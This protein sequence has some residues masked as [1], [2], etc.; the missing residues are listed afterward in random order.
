M[1]LKDVKSS[2][3]PYKI[4]S[5]MNVSKFKDFLIKPMPRTKT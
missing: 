4:I 1:Q 3:R 5:S 2:N